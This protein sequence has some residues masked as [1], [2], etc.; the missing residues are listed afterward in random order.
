M[1]PI[2]KPLIGQDEIRGVVDVLQS[3]TIAEGPRVKE[4]EEAFA[5][6]VPRSRT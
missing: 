3:G 2:A 4:F 5:I 6:A 1:I